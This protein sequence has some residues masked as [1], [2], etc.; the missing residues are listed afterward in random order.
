MDMVRHDH[1]LTVAYYREDPEH[2]DASTQA[3]G[4][5]DPVDVCEIGQRIHA[6]GTVVPVKVLGTLAMIDEGET[7]WKI[8][9]IDVND[10]LA[11]DLNDVD[12]I[13]KKMPGFLAAT[14]EWFKVYKIPDGKPAN[15]F[16]FDGKPKD[17]EFAHQVV[18]DLHRQWKGLMEKEQV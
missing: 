12:D 15:T 7:D 1:Y 6:S 16:A 14:V 10:P 3:K 4:D 5:G 2:T 13:E 9:A 18:S 11:P 8:L 17:R